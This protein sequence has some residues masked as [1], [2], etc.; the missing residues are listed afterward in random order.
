[1]VLAP[2]HYM[3]PYLW[4]LSLFDQFHNLR[5]CALRSHVRRLND[6]DAM[7]VEGTPYDVTSHVFLYGHGF[8]RYEGFIAVWGTVDN[9]TVDG[10]FVA[11]D[12]LDMEK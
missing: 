8:P 10:N 3:D 1:M 2:L 11:G 9:A 4:C 5:Q 7:L 12:N 6:K